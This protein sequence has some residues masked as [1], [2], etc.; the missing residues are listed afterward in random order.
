[1]LQ[2]RALDDSYKLVT[3][4]EGALGSRVI[5]EQ[6]KGILT[7]QAQVT[8][9][10]AFKRLRAHARTN[11]LRLADVAAALI[12]GRLSAATLVETPVS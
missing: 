4:L 11:N 2:E 7:E 10:A 12:D 6:A 8:L 9:D 3:Q 5:L 1:M